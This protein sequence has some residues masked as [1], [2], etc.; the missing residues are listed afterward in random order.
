MTAGVGPAA[1]GLLGGMGGGVAQAYAT[2]GTSFLS[3]FGDSETTVSDDF[4]PWICRILHVHEDCRDYPEQDGRQRP[5]PAVYVR[6]WPPST[7]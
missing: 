3:F 5:E 1:A 2:V 4:R 7:V 6:T